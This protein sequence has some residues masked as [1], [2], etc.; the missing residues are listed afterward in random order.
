M[1]E[2][3]CHQLQTAA[4]TALGVN[5]SQVPLHDPFRY[6]QADSDIP[7]GIR[8]GEHGAQHVGLPVG[9]GVFLREKA[10][11]LILAQRRRGSGGAVIA[12]LSAPEEYGAHACQQQGIQDDGVLL[13]QQA[14]Q[15]AWTQKKGA[16][17]QGAA[18]ASHTGP[19]QRPARPGGQVEE[20]HTVK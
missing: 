13:P 18:K 9:Q 11:G 1:A 19:E 15:V 7:Q 2:E 3:G 5:G 16:H 17:T 10:D 20:K 14:E 6:A 4:H 8:R 12:Q